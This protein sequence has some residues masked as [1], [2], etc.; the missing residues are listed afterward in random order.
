MIVFLSCVKSK[1]K[2]RC[3]AQ[4]M[5]ISD[6]FIKSLQYA[7][8]LKPTAIYILSAKYGLLKLND[9][10]EPYELTLN[11]MTEK[12]RKMWA[13]KVIKQCQQKGI[14]F[15]DKAIFL[16]GKHYRKYVMTKFKN[17]QAPLSHLGIGKQLQFYKNNIKSERH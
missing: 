12:Q 8:Q 9:M 10:I 2:R 6:L 3:E 14:N 5:Y 15:N 1:R 13:C 4:E 17:S 11:N 7:K 16:C